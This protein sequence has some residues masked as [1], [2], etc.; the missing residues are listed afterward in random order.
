M[1]QQQHLNCPTLHGDWA[2][3]AIGKPGTV[4]LPDRRLRPMA[5][6]AVDMGLVSS[7]RP[8]PQ[9]IRLFAPSCLMPWMAMGLSVVQFR[10]RNMLIYN[11][12]RLSSLNTA[13][14]HP[15]L[16]SSTFSQGKSW[17]RSTSARR[18]LS[19]I[20]SDSQ[21]KL[22]TEQAAKPRD[23]LVKHDDVS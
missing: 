3:L 23:V 21:S 8:N 12:Q 13:K 20:S 6:A 19:A 10:N 22:G 11:L 16:S 18:I 1:T 7:A 2:R 9:F 15:F 17:R 14:D 4:N 5:K